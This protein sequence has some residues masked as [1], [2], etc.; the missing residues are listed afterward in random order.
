MV[1]VQAQVQEKRGEAVEKQT[2]LAS[3][4]SF[5]QQRPEKP[6]LLPDCGERLVHF[7]ICT[8]SECCQSSLLK[9][10]SHRNHNY[11]MSLTLTAA[12]PTKS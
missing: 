7:G 3:A 10:A 8:F 4:R 2:K 9:L 12:N 1:N 11:R 6:F 5:W